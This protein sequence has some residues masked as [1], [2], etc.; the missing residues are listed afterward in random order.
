MGEST[1]GC[2]GC[3]LTNETQ[4]RP[5]GSMSCVYVCPIDSGSLWLYR[6]MERV[7]SLDIN[8]PQRNPVNHLFLSQYGVWA[9]YR[10]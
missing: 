10:S 5:V 9:T 1:I 2:M 8:M 6:E 7:E 4:T 3:P